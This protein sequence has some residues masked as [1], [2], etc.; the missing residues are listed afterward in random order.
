LRDEAVSRRIIRLGAIAVEIR[1]TPANAHVAMHPS[2]TGAPYP[3]PSLPQEPYPACTLRPAAG[4]V[5]SG[6]P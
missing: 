1:V 3:Q 5:I 2:R 4:R 6:D